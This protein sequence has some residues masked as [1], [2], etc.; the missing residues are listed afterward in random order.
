MSVYGHVVISWH[1]GWRSFA[2]G[3][4]QLAPVAKDL[5]MCWLRLFWHCHTPK[6]RGQSALALLA[7]GK[8]F[9]E[10]K[11]HDPTAVWRPNPDKT[12]KDHRG[13]SHMWRRDGLRVFATRDLG[14]LQRRADW[15]QTLG[16]KDD[17]DKG[18]FEYRCFASLC[19]DLTNL[20][21]WFVQDNVDKSW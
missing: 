1:P 12:A 6:S 8:G 11:W 20:D 10:G 14:F 9:G 7:I 18:G 15:M 19:P 17:S 5:S 2:E 16:A 4:R 21:L 3:L 13:S